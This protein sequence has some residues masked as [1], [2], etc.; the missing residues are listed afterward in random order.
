MACFN[1]SRES[2]FDNILNRFLCDYRNTKHCTTGDSPAKLVIGRSLKTRFSSL[3]PP[4]VKEIIVSSQEKLMKN[5]KGKRDI[6]LKKNDNIYVR[7]FTNPNKPSWQKAK[8]KKQL[9]K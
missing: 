4:L 3:K 5:F 9:I 2:D 7:D 1:S 6:N 8:V